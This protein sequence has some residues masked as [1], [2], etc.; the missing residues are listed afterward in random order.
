[1]SYTTA[2]NSITTWIN[3]NKEGWKEE[4][5]ELKKRVNNFK[6]DIYN[7]NSIT[8]GNE[9]NIEFISLQIKIM[10]YKKKILFTNDEI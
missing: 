7:L 3:Y 9:Y 4:N 2:P 1:M 5:E 6:S 8:K 10:T